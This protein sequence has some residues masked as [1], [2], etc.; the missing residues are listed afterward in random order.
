MP[1]IEGARLKLR[2]KYISVTAKK[3]HNFIK[4]KDFTIISNNC[5]AGFVY[6]SYNLPYNTPTIG[7]Y[8]MAEDYIKFLSNL[9]GYINSELTFINPKDSRYVEILK[10]DKKFGEYPIG[11]LNDIEIMF[12]HYQ[13]EKEALDKWNKRCSRINWDKLLVKFNDQNGCLKKHLESFDNLDIKNKVCFTSKDYSNL[14]STI[15]I[16]SA[17]KQESVYASQEPF[18]KSKYIDITKLIDSL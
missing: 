12:L 15:Y 8:F 4:N 14:K 3:R 13:S 6:Q 18:G 2:R 16:N 7:L 11:K 9:Q 1:S 5:W 10:N 17:K